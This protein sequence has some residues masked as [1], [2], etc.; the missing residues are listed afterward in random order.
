V[1]ANDFDEQVP[2]MP[3][4]GKMIRMTFASLMIVT[5]FSAS[6]LAQQSGREA[7]DNK[8]YA[9]QQLKYFSSPPE[10]LSALSAQDRENILEGR[11]VVIDLL[12]ALS[13]NR[14]GLRYLTPAF[15]NKLRGG[16]ELLSEVIAP[17]TIL[18]A[19]SVSDYDLSNAGKALQLEMA[20]ISHS[21]G[22]FSISEMTVSLRKPATEWKIDELR[23]V[24]DAR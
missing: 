23:I 5:T 6:A 14:D 10:K 12:R 11:K 17:E 24:N 4:G 1:N 21:E 18:L 8:V 13:D 7:F 16:A 9:I 22:M 3:L 20:V 2:Q 19:V 15:A